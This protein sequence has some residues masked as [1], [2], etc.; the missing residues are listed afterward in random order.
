MPAAPSSLIDPAIGQL[1][2][3]V[4]SLDRQP[5]RLLP[6]L[7]AMPDPRARRGIRHRLAVILGLASCA[8]LAGARSFTA[9][10]EWAAD[11]D[12]ATRDALGVTGT[13]PCESTFRRTLQ[14][15]DADALDEAAG[16]WAQQR[17]APAA[18]ARRAVA[19]DGKTLR[20]SGTADGPGRHLLAA[21]ITGTAWSWARSM[22]RPR[23]TRSRCSQRCWTA[24]TWPGRWSLQTRCPPS[25]PTPSTWPASAART[26]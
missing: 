4:Q 20:G 22:S 12:Q 17:T 14:T 9:I 21:L 10:A 3:A 19:A 18:G 5:A 26:T 24:S 7:A 1:L 23:R 8:V 13:V 16:G 6:V 11:T 2:A 15:L 25:A